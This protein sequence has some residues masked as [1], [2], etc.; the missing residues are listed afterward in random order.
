MWKRWFARKTAQPIESNQPRLFG[1]LPGRDDFVRIGDQDA[2]TMVLAKWLQE[3]MNMLGRRIG[4]AGSMDSLAFPVTRFLWMGASDAPASTGVIVPS[5]DRAGRAYPAVIHRLS[6]LEGEPMS[7]VQASMNNGFLDAATHWW[8]GLKSDLDRPAVE[9]SLA[10]LA[11]TVGSRDPGVLLEALAQTLRS[12]RTDELAER[13]FP[14]DPARQMRDFV[15][16]MDALRRVLQDRDAARLKWGVRLPIAARATGH[17]CVFFWLSLFDALF[18]DVR[19]RLHAFWSW[20]REG[21]PGEICV[22]F[23]PP[24]AAYFLELIGVSAP[25]ATTMNVTTHFR[26]LG[27]ESAETTELPS[28]SLLELMYHW[29]RGVG[30]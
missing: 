7:A 24:P 29:S 27:M 8:E 2:N 16:G 30:R 23:G 22:F 10:S 17:R 18:R 21:R 26:G 14:D 25:N 9:Q 11:P 12:S 4:A 28:C 15:A 3:G 20:P 6:R 13:W 1:K 19:C 5:R